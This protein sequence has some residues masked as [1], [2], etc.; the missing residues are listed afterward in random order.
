MGSKFKILSIDGGGARGIFPTHILKRIYEE[1]E[2]EDFCKEFDLIVGTSTGSIIAAGLAIGKP[3]EKIY[4]LYLEEAEKIFSEKN[5]FCKG[6]ALKSRYKKDNLVGLLK[7]VFK[8]KKIKD[9]KTRLMI[10]ATDLTNGN[11]YIHKSNYDKE[12]V[13][14]KET[15]LYKAVLSSCSAPI[16]F[17]PEK[18]KER[19][20]LADGGLWANNPALLAYTE[21]ISRLEINH[22]N[23]HILSLGTGVGKEYYNIDQKSWGACKLNKKLID[24]VLNLQSANNNN[25]CKHLLGDKQYLRLN[26]E[27][28]NKLPL[29]KLPENW[30]AIAD[31][32]F[33]YNAQ[34][35][36][37]FFN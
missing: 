17:K 11:I 8:D 31:Q 6:Y 30:R 36:E 14:D 1:Y 34:K 28:D 18:I 5:G 26:Y 32:R 4:K 13:R 24:L 27:S 15:L 21:A 2:I 12:F 23:I 37:S 22:K 16:Y 25:I 29:E 9:S 10:P 33:T 3:I 20:L 35:I 7:K 19:Y